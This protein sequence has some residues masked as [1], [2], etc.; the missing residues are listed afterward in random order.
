[1]F[2]NQ[3]YRCKKNI[4]LLDTGQTENMIGTSYTHQLL[5]TSLN[6]KSHHTKFTHKCSECCEWCKKSFA[7]FDNPNHIGRIRNIEKQNG[8]LK[9][10]PTLNI[11]SCLCDRCFKYLERINKFNETEKKKRNFQLK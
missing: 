7:I 4:N 8:L 5:K 3:M 6:N 2:P 9:I 10:E 1:M 11:N